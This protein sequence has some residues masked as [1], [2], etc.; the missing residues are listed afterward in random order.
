[1]FGLKLAATC[2]L[3]ALANG[4]FTPGSAPSCSDV[5]T[6]AGYNLLPHHVY[7]QLFINCDAAGNQFVQACGPGTIYD[8][9]MGFCTHIVS[10]T[11]NAWTCNANTVGRKYPALCRDQYFTCQGNGYRL[12]VC[13]SGQV[14]DMTSGNCINP[15]NPA[16]YVDHPF[17]AR[18]GTGNANTW[19]C[20]DKA[21]S[22][23]CLYTTETPSMRIE[24]RQCGAGTSFNQTTCQCSDFNSNCGVSTVNYAALKARDDQCRASLNV[25]FNALPLVATTEKLTSPNTPLPYTFQTIGVTVAGGIGTFRRDPINY[26]NVYAYG[27]FFNANQLA[28]PWAISVVFRADQQSGETFTVLSNVYLADACT[29]TLEVNGVYNGN[30]YTITINVVGATATGAG[31]ENRIPATTSAGINV[32]SGNYLEVLLTFDSTLSGQLI[33]RGSSGTSN[34]NKVEIPATPNIGAYVATNRCGFSFGKNLNGAIDRITVRE[35]CTN[36]SRVRV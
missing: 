30:R 28:A 2:L 33:D 35:G 10:A 17:C 34:N 9:N 19:T 26:N 24:N 23:P 12:E 14:F 16:S 7:C 8:V 22:N 1:M 6:Q 11:C 29:P 20:Y 3:L 31:T 32:N 15:A 4:Q 27:Y 5:R 36:F 18:A 21:Q 13:P 25:D